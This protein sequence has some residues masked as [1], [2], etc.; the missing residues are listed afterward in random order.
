LKGVTA[1]YEGIIPYFPELHLASWFRESRNEDVTIW[2]FHKTGAR[3]LLRNYRAL[4]EHLSVDGILLVD[5]GVDSLIRGD[6]AGTGT[7]IEDAISLF[8][9]NELKQI[10][11]RHLACIGFGAEQ[12][13]AYRHILENI[14]NITAAGGFLGA[15]SLTKQMNAYRVYEDAVLYVQGRKLQDPSVINSS[16]VSS[17]Q[18]RYGNYH[19][20]GK[21]RG[22]H[23]WISPLMSLYWF[24]DATVVA[25]RNLFLPQLR[26]TDTFMEALRAYMTYGALIPRRPH[27]PIPLP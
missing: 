4:T 19:L 20:T 22:S 16:I 13:I 18:G 3:P 12:D 14:A 10:G 21:T 8:A 11:T 15:C 24:F 23:L 2:C 1:G 17:V 27:A 25:R 5:G 6:E 9:V 26:N 7:L